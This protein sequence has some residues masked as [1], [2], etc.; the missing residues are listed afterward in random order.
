MPYSTQ[1]TLID[2]SG[3]IPQPLAARVWEL[4]RVIDGNGRIQ[5]VQSAT[6][7]ALVPGGVVSVSAGPSYLDSSRHEIAITVGVDGEPGPLFRSGAYDTLPPGAP[8]D[9]DGLIEIYAPAEPVRLRAADLAAMLP[10]VPLALGGGV[11]ITGLTVGLGEGTL[12]VSATGTQSLAFLPPAGFTYA[13]TFSITPSMD[14]F[15]L[16]NVFE[17]VPT[18]PGVLT[19][20]AVGMIAGLLGTTESEI[21]VDV[22]TGLTSV[23]DSAANDAAAAVLGVPE[24]ALGVVV[25]VRKVVITPAGVALFPAMGAYG[26]VLQAFLHDLVDG[27]LLREASDPRIYLI[28]GG[29]KLWVP[30]MEELDALGLSG[31]P[32]RVVPVGAMALVPDVPRGTVPDGSLAQI[33]TGPQIPAEP[34]ECAML[35]AG[36]VDRV[37]AIASLQELML[38]LD[39]Q[40]LIDRAELQEFDRRIEQLRQEITALEAQGA[41]LGCS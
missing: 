13:L 35:R 34:S 17:I 2:L 6:E 33:P 29:A 15:D 39:G 23:L 26:G 11:T 9:P 37:D 36:I 7:A 4:W 12:T 41:T 10:A 1:V 22:I 5:H 14:L 24:L 32:V 20:P 28:I 3:A 19:P 8:A 30:I 25:S 38:E 16:G 40:D 27:T 21:R 31:A 18:G